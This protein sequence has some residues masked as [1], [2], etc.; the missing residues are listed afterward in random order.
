MEVPE[1]CMTTCEVNVI[2]QFHDVIEHIY[3]SKGKG[4]FLPITGQEGPEEE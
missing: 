4:K 2:G 1:L 3:K